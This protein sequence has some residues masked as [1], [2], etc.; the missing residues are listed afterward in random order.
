MSARRRGAGNQFFRTQMSTSFAPSL[1]ACIGLS[2]F[3]GF[4]EVVSTMCLAYP[5]FKKKSG[6]HFSKAATRGL[7][8]ANL[9]LM[10]IASVAYIVGSWFGPVSLS[11]PTVMVSKLLFNLGVMGSVLKMQKFTKAQKVGTYCIA[12]AIITLPDVGPSEQPGQDALALVAEPVAI[13]WTAVLTVAS[14]GCCVGMAVL[15]RRRKRKPDEPAASERVELA[16]FVTAQVCSAVVGTS[17]SKMLALV[18]ASYIPALIAIAIAFAAINVVSL[19]LAA[20]V[21]DQAVFV[22][23]TILGTLVVNLAT[24]LIIWQDWR[25]ISRWVAYFAVHLVMFLGI[26]LLGPEDSVSTYKNQ[27]Q[28]CTH[29]LG[30]MGKDGRMPECLNEQQA[31][32]TV[33]LRHAERAEAAGSGSSATPEVGKAAAAGVAPEAQAASSWRDV[34]GVPTRGPLVSSF[35]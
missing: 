8:V 25:V 1:P 11:V 10:G 7:L 16:V 34:M 2:A 13:A 31:S 5:E 24:G 23:A 22:P 35:V 17:V 28:Y 14:V 29:T 33:F 15:E 30:S 19:M 3:G 9:A 32:K 21:V 4:L 27:R 18:D 6:K 12:T 26:S 20:K